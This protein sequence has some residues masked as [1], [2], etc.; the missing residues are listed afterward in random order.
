MKTTLPIAS[1][2]GVLL[3][4]S[5]APAPSAPTPDVILIQTSA[6]Q[7]VVANFTLT[8]AAFSPTAPVATDTPTV[9]TTPV[10]GVPTDTPTLLPGGVTA[11]PTLCDALSFD[12]A[13]VDVNVPDNTAMQLGQA[14]VKT[15]R[16]RNNGSCTW[17]A[18]YKLVFSY[19]SQMSG[20]PQPFTGVVGPG[21]EIELSINFKAPT[22]AGTYFSA[23]QMSN[24]AGKAFPKVVYVKIVVK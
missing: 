1:M 9:E 24:A 8:A 13:T 16:V 23:W 19:G 12:P 3:L 15:W 20:V 11:T 10:P 22:Q 18:G 7:T 17:G 4:A 14:F 5:C 6:A 2:I 21:Q